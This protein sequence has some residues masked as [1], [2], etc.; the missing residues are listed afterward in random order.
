M[1]PA[2]DLPA[3][4]WSW[5]AR[6]SWQAAVLVVLVLAVQWAFRRR[7]TPRWRCALWWL[8][9]IRLTLP[10]SPGSALSI[11]NWIGWR[12]APL[13]AQAGPA[14]EPV[15]PA[16]LKSLEFSAGE[17]QG[18]V[19]VEGALPPIPA[20]GQPAPTSV[21]WPRVWL[22]VWLSGAVLL[23]GR[24]LLET[25]RLWRRLGRG[26]PVR[27]A[28]VVAL[29]E[30][31]RRRMGLARSLTV[32]ET[33]EVQTPALYGLWQPRLLLP[34][35][36]V[37]RFS[38]RELRHVFLHEMAHV[39]RRDIALNWLATV[40]QVW[41]WFNPL[42]WLAFSRMRAD[43]ELACD[44]LALA[45]A[46]PG[47]SRAYGQTIIKLLEEFARPAAA[48]GLVGILED[49]NQMQ[50]RIRM[51]ADFR[52]APRWSLA[53]LALLAAA[54]LV[55]LT[56]A[57]SPQA[58]P[59]T[60]PA[61]AVASSAPAS[62]GQAEADAPIQ[63]V[64]APRQSNTL[65]ATASLPNQPP[66]RG[67]AEPAAQPPTDPRRTET[68]RRLRQIRIKSLSLENRPLGEVV[69][70]L[71]EAVRQVDH[72]VTGLTFLLEEPGAPA[73]KGPGTPSASQ[74]NPLRWDTPLS[75]IV[76]RTAKPLRNATLEEALEAITRWAQPPLSYRVEPTAVVIHRATA[77]GRALYTRIFKLD[78]KSL[79]QALD[80]WVRSAP[81][82]TNRTSSGRVGPEPEGARR[83]GATPGKA[84]GRQW[85]GGGVLSPDHRSMTATNDAATRELA[86][87]LKGFLAVMGVE[88][89]EGKAMF[90]NDRLGTLMV[91]ATAADCDMIERAVGALNQSPP[92]LT[93]RAR[94]V[95]VVEDRRDG[96]DFLRL[97]GATN[98]SSAS[99][100][101][102]RRTGRGVATNE[103][104]RRE[105][106]E[107]AGS[108]QP[109]TN[110][111]PAQTT[112]ILSPARFREVLKA[113][114]GRADVQVLSSPEVTTVSGRQAQ[115][116]T[117]DIKSVVTHLERA[118][119]PGADPQP[120]SEPIE[121][122]PVLDVVPQV[123][124]D[125]V[126][127]RMTVIPTLREFA[128]YDEEGSRQIQAAVKAKTPYPLPIFHLR[129]AVATA[130][131][132][133]G[134]TLVL[135]AGTI[136]TEQKFRETSFPSSATHTE[137]VRKTLYIFVT[138]TLIDPAGNPVHS[139]EETAWPLRASPAASPANSG[140][141]PIR[142]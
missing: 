16:P 87:N 5:L 107:K 30:E 68:F 128:G 65:A 64:Q 123:S 97:L 81:A 122:G 11:F 111:P 96:Q 133:D 21:D 99:S 120:I 134:Q 45:A 3:L 70:D 23:S 86:S 61:P 105:P 26:V 78:P 89:T 88:W 95:Q 125:G 130:S 13:A 53:G 72:Q 47:E 50:Q 83:G 77:E 140:R 1:M 94:F 116:K 6:A 31:C 108:P 7:L 42:V 135:S 141:P 67:A 82:T 59:E 28:G 114:E 12:A 40:L 10:V 84:G 18:P 15:G 58:G 19:A 85:S 91:R 51:I 66:G 48:P 69:R 44:A 117:V 33:P 127:I 98:L 14:P 92:Q 101:A 100:P 126:T 56:D 24:V 22:W 4:V 54:A 57:P 46:Q 124:P 79:C 90:F 29:L 62:L 109:L 93:I 131:L 113:M 8:V 9:L 110:L 39:R 129:Q 55:G 102:S 27:E 63:P 49:R 115:V 17:S 35:G 80:D 138:P 103:S 34:V 36:F 43:R 41:H 139:E 71:A 104:L 136:Q 38:P 74:P 132:R 73:P 142:P 52:S 121:C 25:A 76:L 112:A 118:D 37:H 32:V 2:L 119:Q 137:V 106:P 20:R 60:A 75:E